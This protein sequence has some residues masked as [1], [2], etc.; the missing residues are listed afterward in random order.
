MK[1]FLII[2]ITVLLTGGV[3]GGG[4]WWYMKDK[5][6][7]EQQTLQT[8]ISNLQKQ[9][10]ELKIANSGDTT[11]WKSYSSKELGLTF[12][13]PEV[14]GEP[15]SHSEDYSSEK[16]N[17]PSFAGRSYSVCFSEGE[18]CVFGYSADYKV[19]ESAAGSYYI[20]DKKS[21]DVAE[22]E[23][24]KDS[25]KST[26]SFVQKAEAAGVK[27]S[28][29]TY[30]YYLSEASGVGV[31][32]LTFLNGKADYPGISISTHYEDLSKSLQGLYEQSGFESEALTKQAQ[33]EL[34]ALKAGSSNYQIQSNLYKLW[35][36]TFSYL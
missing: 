34:T 10:D 35:L 4:G 12:K 25:E 16:L 2:L 22:T 33:D 29:K 1:T 31:S 23:V 9:A 15:V 30:F 17:N 7:K 32:S 28:I 19:Y 21:L 13:Y 24:V 8:Q 20:G 6:T 27:T 14:W 18:Y 36:G 26:I 11:S 5:A 3:V